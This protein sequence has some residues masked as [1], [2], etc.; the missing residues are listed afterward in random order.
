MQN[1]TQLFANNGLFVG[2]ILL[3][4][5]WFLF[6]AWLGLRINQAQNFQFPKRLGMGAVLLR[7]VPLALVSVGVTS[8]VSIQTA[9]QKVPGIDTGA[10]LTQRLDAEKARLASTPPAPPSEHESS[11][12][13]SKRMLDEANAQN[14][15]AKAKFMDSNSGN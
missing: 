10:L 5:P 6:L 11:E 14:E 7:L 2:V 13:R 4:V 15:A 3:A 8:L 9:Y 1:V 12:Q